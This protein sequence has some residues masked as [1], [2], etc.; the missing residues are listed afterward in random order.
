MKSGRCN[1]IYDAV[2]EGKVIKSGKLVEKKCSKC[3]RY[4]ELEEF[5]RQNTG[6]VGYT[7][8]CHRC[9]RDG[10]YR[11]KFG[12]GIEY[13]EFA[14]KQQGM[15]CAL[16]ERKFGGF[17]YGPDLEIR[18]KPV[19]DHDHGT[20]IPRGVLCGKCNIALGIIEGNY[21]W[22]VD[23]VRYIRRH[24]SLA[25]SYSIWKKGFE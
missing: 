6:K 11:K 9:T 22:L 2:Y 10:M 18:D 23:A 12:V 15:R 25:Q 5:P 13:F 14:L 7:A 16:C 1:Q 3:E 8:R 17:G 4:L 19:L 24:E 21:E 20:N